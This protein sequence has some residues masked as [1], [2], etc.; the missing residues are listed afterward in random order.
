MYVDLDLELAI[1]LIISKARSHKHS[2]EPHI[3]I[4]LS[5]LELFLHFVAKLFAK[6]VLQVPLPCSRLCHR[7]HCRHPQFLWTFKPHRSTCRSNVSMKMHRLLPLRI[8]RSCRYVHTPTNIIP[9][10]NS[11]WN[12]IG[13]TSCESRFVEIVCLR[14]P[15]FRARCL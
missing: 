12:S 14:C 8:K 13:I 6:N 11:V 3:G 7:D 4:S 2:S 1:F 15:T 9:S 5:F 10:I